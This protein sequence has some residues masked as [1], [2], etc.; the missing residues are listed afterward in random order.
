MDLPSKDYVRACVSTNAILLVVLQCLAAPS[1][2]QSPAEFTV[3]QAARGEAEYRQSCALCHGE[4]LNDGPFGQPL[5]GAYFRDRWAGHTVDSLFDQMRTTMPPDRIGGLSRQTY[6]DLVAFLFQANGA[7]PTDQELPADAESLA[8]VFVP[9]ARSSSQAR[10]RSGGPG[11]TI[12]MGVALPDWPIPED[13]L[14]DIRFVTDELLQNPPPESWL[15]WRRTYDSLGHSPLDQID[16]RNVANLRV[17]WT[18]SLPPG[19]NESTPLVHDGVMFVHSYGDNIQA[20]DAKTGNELWHYARELPDGM[21][22]DV[23]RNIAIFGDKVYA[24]TTDLHVVALGIKTGLVVWATQIAESPEPGNARITGGPLVAGGMVMQGVVGRMPGGAYIQAL[25]AETGELAWR[26]NSIP[27][28]DEPGGNSWNGIPLEERTGGSIW[29]AG[30]YDPGTNLFYTGPAPTYDTGP[31]LVPSGVVGTNNDALYTNATV[32]IV[33][34]TGEIAW[35]FQHVRNDPFDL[36][37]AFE[38][39]ILD[40]EVNGI[41]RRVSLTAGKHGFYDAIDAATGDYLFSYDM[42]LQNVILGVDRETGEKTVDESLLPLDGEPKL[43]CPFPGGGRSWIPGSLNPET[44][45]MYVPA[46]ESCMDYAPI[47]G[48]GQLNAGYQWRMRP[49]PNSDGRYGH[50]QAINVETREMLWTERQRAPQSTGVLS[51]DGGLVFAGALDRKLTAYDDA[52]GEQLWSTVLND[53]PN[54]NPISYMVDGKQ[55]IA[56]VVGYGGA[57]VA[58]FP[59]LVPEISLPTTQS[60]SIWVFELP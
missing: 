31:M 36:D 51:T 52:S 23:K 16:Q 8:A 2:A 48:P 35:H 11:G 38:R 7:T 37:W 22:P 49:R 30:S 5:A 47:D 21:R 24:G 45:I 27:R 46:V 4:N 34:Q 26:F 42:G 39:M 54:S 15:H 32:A 6:A 55:Y 19:P 3:E 13:P 50:L 58:T 10:L 33:P 29:T 57:Q 20:F 41:P 59:R 40:L 14:E 9:G 43:V 25:D 1:F 12:S 44:N 53:V 28:P 60:S 17:A 18:L 56:M